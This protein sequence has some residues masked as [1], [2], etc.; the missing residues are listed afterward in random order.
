MKQT[1]SV[2]KDPQSVLQV[3]TSDNTGSTQDTNGRATSEPW[4]PHRLTPSHQRM[5]PDQ[6][7]ADTRAVR[8]PTRHD[9]LTSCDAAMVTRDQTGSRH[10]K[11]PQ[12][13]VLPG[14]RRP[15]GQ[16]DRAGDPESNKL[17]A[18]FAAASDEEDQHP[19]PPQRLPAQEPGAVRSDL[20]T[21]RTCSS[22]R[23]GRRRTRRRGDRWRCRRPGRGW[24]R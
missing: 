20:S 13:R 6:S 1:S 23:R 17:S 15:R 3:L 14:C 18:L 24:R 9:R 8:D 22:G 5:T 16:F 10:E 7:S 4:M 12:E 21:S 19:R 11:T 2:R